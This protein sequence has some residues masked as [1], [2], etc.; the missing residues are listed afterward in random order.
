MLQL[1]QRFRLDLPDAFA[2]HRELLAHFFQ[3]VVS[4]HADAETHAQHAFFAWRQARQHA[5]CGFAQIGLNG[6][7]DGQNSTLV[8]D[9][10]TQM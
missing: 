8:F 4:V 6:G 1:P 10:V 7:V 3:R 5:R 2:C 9:E